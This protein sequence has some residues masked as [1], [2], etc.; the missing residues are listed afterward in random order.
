MMTR[1]IKG[2]LAAAIAAT[3]LCGCSISR[4]CRAPELNLPSSIISGETPADQETLADMQW[5]N[6][7]GDSPPLQYNRANA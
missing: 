1:Y 4:K 2:I 5:W 6:F 3:S 7:Y